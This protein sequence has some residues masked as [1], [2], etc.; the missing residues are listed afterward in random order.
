MGLLAACGG[1]A[2]KAVEVQGDTLTRQPR[3]LTLVD[4][5]A[6][7]VADVTDP[8]D[9]T[10]LLERYVLV[11]RRAPLPDNLPEGTVLR[12]PLERSIVYS[13]V[14]GG[15]IRQLGGVDGIAGVAEGKYFN[16]AEIKARIAS[17]RI[18]DV[19]SSMSPTVEKIIALR[20][21]AVLLS[22]YQNAGDGVVGELG[23]PLVRM[24][25]YMEP[26]PLGRAEWL[27][28][29]GELYGNPAGADSIY[30]A[31]S[32]R[33]AGLK[34]LADATGSRPTVVT[35]RVADGVWYVP[36]GA[37]YSAALLRDAGASYLW[38]GDTSAGSLQ[39]DFATVYARAHDADCW[40]L[41]SYGPVTLE[42]LRA[43]YPLNAKM[44]PW[45]TAS[46]WNADTSR[47]TLF[48]DFPFR[49]DTLLRDYIIIFH[50]E[51]GL[52]ETTYF[53]KVEPR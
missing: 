5:G 51:L 25:D 7:R 19:G 22:P 48:D 16:D 23:V 10:R 38:E 32:A 39:L 42:S 24:A 33:Y 4:C 49:P 26:T 53:K 27:K 12:T 52:G 17:G 28:F 31:A 40:L 14:H 1:G 2:E 20:P 9:T 35:E 30:R 3:L 46:V 45:S 43:E 47:A 37:S 18:A 21:D 6:Y 41:R 13:G 34:E 29:I 15:A 50:P 11:P 44:R 8:W 36:G